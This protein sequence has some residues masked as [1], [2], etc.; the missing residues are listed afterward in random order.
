MVGNNCCTGRPETES[1]KESET[2]S[3]GSNLVLVEEFIKSLLVVL[4]RTEVGVDFDSV[5]TAKGSEC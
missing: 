5:T 1:G 3:Y 2:A 4:M